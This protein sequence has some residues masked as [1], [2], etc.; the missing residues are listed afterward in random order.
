MR[1]TWTSSGLSPA[2]ATI[3]EQ[4]LRLS[5][6]KDRLGRRRAGRQAE[7]QDQEERE[8]GGKGAP[9]SQ[10]NDSFSHAA[11]YPLA[12]LNLT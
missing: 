11:S 1:T 5:V 7:G 12:G 8:A 4:K 10:R 6:A 3:L 9:P 2:A